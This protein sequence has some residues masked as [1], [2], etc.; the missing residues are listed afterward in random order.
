VF[1]EGATFRGKLKSIALQEVERTFKDD[2]DPP[3]IFEGQRDREA[4][5]ERN[6]ADL[7]ERGKFLQHGTDDMVRESARHD[8]YSRKNLV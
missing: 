7:L 8:S 3:E 5:I 4:L 2:L 1:K 6:V